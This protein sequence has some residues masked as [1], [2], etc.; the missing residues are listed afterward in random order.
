MTDLR[1]ARARAVTLSVVIVSH[2][3][4]AVIEDCL[5][6]LGAELQDVDSE[7]FVVDS[8]SSDGTVERVEARFP[9]AHLD[10]ARQN[11]GFA[12]GN[13][14]ALPRCRGRYV[15]LLN[16]DTVVQKGALQILLQHLDEHPDVGAV[17][18][19][20]CLADGRTQPECARN[21]PRLGNI[22]PWLL[23]LDKLTWGLGRKLG[24]SKDDRPRRRWLDDFCLL[25]WTREKS[26]S[27]EMVGGACMMV[28]AS[29]MRRIGWLDEACPLYLDDIDYCRR[30]RDAGYG[31]RYVAEATITH[32]W[33]HSSAALD[34]DG[35]FYALGCHAI[36]LFLKKHEGRL[37]ARTFAMMACIAGPLRVAASSILI[38]LSPSSSIRTYWRRQFE[39]AW[40]LSR[41]AFRLRKSAPRFGFAGEP[42]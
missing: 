25:S 1:E 39:M 18:P 12:A 19:R 41:W 15:L 14:R 17:G 7:V 11:V 6:S 35:D 28:R 27:V 26:A 20:V 3:D 22:F 13:N 29:V 37:A 38:G 33:Q 4:E 24:G 32:L 5:E 31:I 34:R 30:I 16:P 40:A 23:L 2:N 9:W 8:G 36:W 10:A 42:T 21:L